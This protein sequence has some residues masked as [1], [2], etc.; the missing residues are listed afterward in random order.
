MGLFEAD[1][2]SEH[3]NV[4]QYVVF[5][6]GEHIHGEHIHGELTPDGE[7]PDITF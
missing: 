6:N 5:V 3:R 7:D 2:G 1:I 4:N